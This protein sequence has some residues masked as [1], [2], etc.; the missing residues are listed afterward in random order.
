MRLPAVLLAV[1]LAGVVGGA[2]LIGMAAVGGAII[3]DSL[4]VAAWAVFVYDDGR[5]VP[6]V[7]EVQGTV[8]SV[9]ER[10]RNAS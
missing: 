8:A 3:F 10:A 7:R 1:S 5:T 2:W 9:L 4:V 6:Q